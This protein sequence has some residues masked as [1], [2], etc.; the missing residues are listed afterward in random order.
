MAITE[1]ARFEMHLKLRNILGE[2]VAETLMEHLPPSGWGDVARKSD[3]DL[4]AVEMR[5]LITALDAKFESKTNGFE[6][7]FSHIDSRLRGIVAGMWAMGGIMSAFF[8]AI[9][10]KI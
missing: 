5:H 9:L 6:V 4:L 3:L 10:T 2:K 1:D 8:V 7:R